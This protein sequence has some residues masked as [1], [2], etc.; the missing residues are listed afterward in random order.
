MTVTTGWST[1]VDRRGAG[2]GTLGCVIPITADT[3]RV[4]L[5]VI[6]ATLWIGGQAVLAALVPALRPFGDEVVRTAARRFQLVAW[7]AFA[8]LVATG[9][10]NLTEVGWSQIDGDYA[11]TL[12]VKLSLVVLSGVCAAVH[13]LIAGPRVR[14]ATIEADA[15]RARALSG[16]TGAGGLA[17]AM[18]AAFFGVQL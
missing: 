8:L 10:W 15:S 3:I 4:F 13:S 17:F 11:G 18:G 14:R 6:G 5:H 16:I 7:P 12:V 2:R 9:I 1:L